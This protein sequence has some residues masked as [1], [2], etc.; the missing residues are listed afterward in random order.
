MGLGA[1]NLAAGLFQGY[2]VAGG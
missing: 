1:A 2:P